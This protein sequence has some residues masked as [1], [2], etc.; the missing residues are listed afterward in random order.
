[1][2][3]RFSLMRVITSLSIAL[4]SGA[5]APLPVFAQTKVDKASVDVDA[6]CPLG[7]DRAKSGSALAARHLPHDPRLVVFPYDRNALYPVNTYF[8][9]FTHFEFESGERIVASYINDET[10]WEMKVSATGS[11]IFVRPRVRG[12]TGSMTTISD[13]RRYQIDLV[14][15]SGCVGEWRYQRVSWSHV[16]GVYEDKEALSRQGEGEVRPG[17]QGQSLASVVDE[18]AQMPLPGMAAPRLVKPAPTISL[19]LTTINSAYEIEGDPELAPTSVLD[20]GRRT[21]LKFSAHMALRPVLF[22][23]DADGKAEAVEYVASDSHFLVNRLFE[24]GLQLKL[25]QREVRVRNK[26][27]SCGWLDKT[28]RSGRAQNILAN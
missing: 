16:G 28:C 25:G 21:I 17:R 24:H 27:S 6:V 14:D 19:D 2:R 7:R 5:V 15:T 18:D 26:N 23:V 4:G 11:D 10:E 22:A 12:A 9:R 8:N 3:Q 13:R 1:M 20:D